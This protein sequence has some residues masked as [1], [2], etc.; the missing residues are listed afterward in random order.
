VIEDTPRELNPLLGRV[1]ALLRR[2]Q[3]PPRAI[4]DD[5]PVLT[6]I[7]D[8]NAPSRQAVDQ[9]VIEALAE[10][11]ERAVLERLGPELDRVIDSR[12]ARAL[13]EVLEQALQDVRSELGENVRQ[14]VREA[15]ATSVTQALAAYGTSESN[16]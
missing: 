10:A 1:D 5:V 12:L 2:H 8:P 3:E 9:A 6:E 15:V 14:M 7:A 11:L 16:N 13:T 4:D